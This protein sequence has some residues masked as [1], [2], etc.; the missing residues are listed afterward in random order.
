MA[1][2]TEPRAISLRQE[3]LN[4]GF[5]LREAASLIGVSVAALQ[6]AEYGMSV[7]PSNGK[8]I[9]DFYGRQVSEIWPVEETAA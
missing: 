9:A 8:A 5:T 3:R 7:S 2:G 1:S 6:R 4:K